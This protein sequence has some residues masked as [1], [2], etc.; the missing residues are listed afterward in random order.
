MSE[1]YNGWTNRETWA[2]MLHVSNDQVL[3]E[4]AEELALDGATFRTDR[5]GAVGRLAD[6]LR[7]WVESLV[8]PAEYRAE[9]GTE[10]PEGLQL[11]AADIGSLWRVDWRE[12]AEALLDDIGAEFE[13]TA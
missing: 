11:M 4:R 2:T 9:F 7:Y 3:R 13:V 8:N 12:C 5:D 6:V 1:E 10:Q